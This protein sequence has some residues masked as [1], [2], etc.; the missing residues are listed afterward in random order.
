MDIRNIAIIAHV[1]HGKTTLV[2]QLSKTVRIVPRKPASRRTSARSKRSR[3]G[4]RHYHSGQVHQRGLGPRTASTPASISSTR[5]DMPISAV[6]SSAFSAW[7]TAPSCSSMPPKACCRRPSSCSPRPWRRGIKPIVVVN[8]VDRGDARADEVHTEMF[9]LFAAL[10]ANDDQLDF[11]M[12]YRLGPSGLGRHHHGRA[13]Q[14]PQPAIQ[15]SDVPRPADVKLDKEAPFAMV[16]SI[17]DYDNFLGRV[18]TGRVEQ[19]RARLN[20]PVKVLRSDGTV[21]R[22]RASD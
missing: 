9:D 7:S 12:L 2:D 16:A 8:K 15:Y 13:P 4:T 10:G 5:L 11:P 6:R 14:G 3:A 17:L 20:M 21:G 22:N 1:D 18:L 19:G